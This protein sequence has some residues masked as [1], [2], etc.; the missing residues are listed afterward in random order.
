M[1]S[2]SCLIRFCSSLNSASDSSREKP[3]DDV[4]MAKEES[5]EVESLLLLLSGAGELGLPLL[6]ES[7][8]LLGENMVGEW[9][10]DSIGES[11]FEGDGTWNGRN[12]F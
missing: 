11:V 12:K 1:E 4:G 2:F 8:A 9:A 3:E 10:C 6:L 7:A 5:V